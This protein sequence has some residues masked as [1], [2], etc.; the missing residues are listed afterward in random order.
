LWLSQGCL[1]NQ[2]RIGKRALYGSGKDTKRDKKEQVTNQILNIGKFY[3]TTKIN[4]KK[5]SA[6]R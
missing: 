4:P 2:E 6:R 5:N 3:K 1:G